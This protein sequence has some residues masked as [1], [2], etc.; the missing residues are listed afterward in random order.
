MQSRFLHSS[1]YTPAW[2]IEDASTETVH[3][4]PGRGGLRA[5]T[6]GWLVKTI[7]SLRFCLKV[8]ELVLLYGGK[9]DVGK[10]LVAAVIVSPASQMDIG[11]QSAG[12]L[13]QI[14]RVHLDKRCFVSAPYRTQCAPPVPCTRTHGQFTS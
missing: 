5:V 4:S 1:D 9:H 2:C 11:L 13:K 3:S 7:S 6:H 14:H 8:V 12:E 10:A